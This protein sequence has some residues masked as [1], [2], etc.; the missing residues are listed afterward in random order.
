MPAGR[1]RRVDCSAP[2]L[3]RRRAGRG[4]TYLDAAGRRVNDVETLARIR[5]LAIPPAWREV[6]I[7][8]DPLGYL[9]ATGIDAARRKQYRY[10]TAGAP[11]ATRRSSTRCS[12]SRA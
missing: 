4:F 11:G 2:G 3:T 10:T 6:W 12:T 9:Q 8:S 5:D 1:L 7:C